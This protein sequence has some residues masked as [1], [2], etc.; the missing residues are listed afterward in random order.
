MALALLLS[1]KGLSYLASDQLITFSLVALCFHFAFP[2]NWASTIS[3]LH[4]Y[5]FKD[6]YIVL[7]LEYLTCFSYYASE[8]YEVRAPIIVISMN[9]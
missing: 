8:T 4:E 7:E 3:F 5:R 1:A 6:V 9:I 2:C